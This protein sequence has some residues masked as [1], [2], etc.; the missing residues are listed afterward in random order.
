MGAQDDLHQLP[1]AAFADIFEQLPIAV[2]AYDSTGLQVAMNEAQAK[3]WGLRR[4]EWVG[5]FNMVTDSQLASQGSGEMFRKVMQG[6]T[7][8]L[9]PHSYDGTATGLQSDATAPVWIEASYFPMR[10]K[11]G[12]VTHLIA[13][14]RD[15]SREILQRQNADKAQEEIANQRMIIETLSNPVIQ[16]WQGILTLPLIG[17]IDSR[18]AMNITEGLLIA[19]AERQA[20]CIIIDITGVPMVDTQVAQHLV[21]TARACQLLGCDVALVGISPEIAQ[22]LVQ[23]GVDLSKLKTL[24]NL[25]A[26]IA[27]AFAQ[28]RLR[29]VSI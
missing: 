20:S 15:V 2:S 7:V 3:L 17:A 26:G 12:E 25:Q 14:L 24:A 19:I 29:V 22:T 11:S 28:Q 13:I 27:W 1:I 21:Q 10:A 5:H 23:L 6:E 16:I 18:R 9:P 4:E 8:V